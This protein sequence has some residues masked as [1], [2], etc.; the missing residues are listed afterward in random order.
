M[1]LIRT[2]E[3]IIEWRG[4]PD[5][6]HCDNGPENIS[7]VMQNWASRKEIRIE[8]IQPGKPQQNAYIER[9]NRTVRYEW[10]GLIC[11][12]VQNISG[13]ASMRSGYSLRNG[14][15]TTITSAQ[16]WP[17]AVSRLNNGWPWP[18]NATSCSY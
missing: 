14:C 3:Q 4:Q 17:W 2:L 15:T 18:H 7:S 1:R 6:I 12:K 9:F 13:K 11:T 10:L 5:V 16:I 8:Y